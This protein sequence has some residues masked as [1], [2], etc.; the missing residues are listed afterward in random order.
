VDLVELARPLARRHPWEQARLRFFRRE[1][2]RAGLVTGGARL[3]DAGAGDGWFSRP[4][5][6]GS[7]GAVSVVCWDVGYDE[8]LLATEAFAAGDGVCFVRE[9]PPGW[10]DVVL[11]LDVLEHVPDDAGF[12]RGMVREVLSPDGHLLVS[13]PA[14]PALF[15]SHDSHLR[16][17]RRYRPAAARRLL[18]EAGLQVL[19]GGGLFHSLLLPRALQAARE[20]WSGRRSPIWARGAAPPSGRASSWARWR[21]MQDCRGSVPR[22]AGISQD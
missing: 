9:R 19:R 10:F 1:L 22:W 16:H 13:V 12:L 14:W 5:V 7:G 3:L 17:Q 21:A 8:A 15:T 11:L 6:A 18:R 2:A 4:L 20:R